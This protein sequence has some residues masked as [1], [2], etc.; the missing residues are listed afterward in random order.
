MALKQDDTKGWDSMRERTMKYSLLHS[1]NHKWF[2]NKTCMDRQTSCSEKKILVWGFLNN[3][4]EF[5]I[6]KDGVF[7]GGGG[8]IKGNCLILWI[9]YSSDK[10]M[11]VQSKLIEIPNNCLCSNWY[12]VNQKDVGLIHLKITCEVLIKIIGIKSRLSS[13]RI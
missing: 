10:N 5:I 9:P 2:W 4:F 7:L 12:K 11:S 1:N 13:P 6:L 8:I 3:I